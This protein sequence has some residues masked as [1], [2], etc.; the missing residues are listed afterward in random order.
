MIRRSLPTEN[1]LLPLLHVHAAGFSGFTPTLPEDTLQSSKQHTMLFW[2]RFRAARRNRMGAR[3]W[4]AGIDVF[5]A[6][7]G[8]LG[9]GL[10]SSDE[11]D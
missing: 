5:L 6:F 8:G 10:W 7:P 11:M 9:W 3:R 2:Q 4:V 1:G